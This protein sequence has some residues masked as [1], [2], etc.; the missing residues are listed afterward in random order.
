MKLIPYSHQWID[1]RDIEEVIEVLKTDWLTT[2]PKIKEFETKLC[3]YT[4][5]K[6]AIVVSSGTAALHI[7]CLAAKIKNQEEAI[8][9]PITFLASANCILYCGGKPVFA[10]IMKDT[11]NIDPVEV[12]KNI[13]LNTRA[14]IPVHF[15]GYPCD[16]EEIKKIADKYSLMVIEDAAHALGAEYKNS[17]IGSCRYSD[18]TILS[19]HP[20]KTI[21]TGEGGA[22]LT[23]NKRLY[24]RLLLLRNHGIDR[25]EKKINKIGK[26]WYYE[27]KELGFNYRLT[28]MQAALGISQLK[29]IDLFISKRRRIARFYNEYFKDNNY[30]D[31]LKE[32]KGVISAYHL[33]P[34]ILKD[35]FKKFRKELFNDMRS[36][37]IG[38]QV[39]YIPV[40]LQPYYR[41]LGYNKNNCPKAEGYYRREI[42]IPIYPSL[43]NSQVEDIARKIIGVFRKYE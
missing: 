18:M 38:V 40:Y 16:L 14:I 9:S 3:E 43:K 36:V 37:G 13:N 21:T 34:I 42:S 30:F 5:V 26:P 7:A 10:D 23:N 24:E 28:D 8:T 19:F 15:A 6:Y 1:E 25:D 11:G 33:Y 17:K 35:R 20:I 41:S 27:M 2:G 29:K 4:G 22:V 32:G 31:N 39:N 12:E